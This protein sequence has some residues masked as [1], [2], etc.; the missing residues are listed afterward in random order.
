[1]ANTPAV[2]NTEAYEEGIR[3]ESYALFEASQPPGSCGSGSPNMEYWRAKVL[4]NR[5]AVAAGEGK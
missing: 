1:M 3:A 2:P 5:A 4:E